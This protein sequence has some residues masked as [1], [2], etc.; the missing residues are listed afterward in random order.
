M[1]VE[2]VKWR[3]PICNVDAGGSMGELKNHMRKVHARKSESR[4]STA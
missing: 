3:C 2:S 4:I 1:G